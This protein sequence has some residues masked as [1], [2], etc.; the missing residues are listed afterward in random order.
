MLHPGSQA[1]TMHLIPDRASQGY[2]A[3]GNSAATEPQADAR[4]A[5]S[6]DVPALIELDF[7]LAT[8]GIE[9][10]KVVYAQRP[11]KIVALDEIALLL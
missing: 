3:R 10:F 9:Y 5:D 11:G 8:L 2:G 7:T 6:N 4:R 1:S